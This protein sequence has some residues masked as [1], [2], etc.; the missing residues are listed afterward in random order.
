MKR[1]A[2]YLGRAFRRE[3]GTASLE[4]VLVVPL[5]LALFMAS[6]ES[7]L[8]M[9]RHTMLERAVDMTIRELRL[10]HYV[11]PNHDML[12]TEICSR[13]VV[14]PDCANVLKITL[15]PVSTVAWNIPDD[16]AVCADRDAV[17]QPITEF[18]PGTPGM[19]EEI[20][21]VRVCATVDALFPT[22]GIGL[23]LPKDSGGG[24]A[25]IAESAFVN[26]PS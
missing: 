22:T 21:L 15:R 26:E 12:R 23:E 17:I 11:N 10:G 6:F 16:Q 3:D 1:L 19:D 2:R 4:F 13:T 18:N 5:V 24:Y 8:L 7:G 25:L 20:M 9:V 14:I